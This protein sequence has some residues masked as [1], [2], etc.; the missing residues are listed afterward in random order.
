MGPT[1]VP[2]PPMATQTIIS[3]EG[4]TATSDGVMMPTWLT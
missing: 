3:M 1:S 4:A 2:L